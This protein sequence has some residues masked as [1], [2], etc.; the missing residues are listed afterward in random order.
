M[1]VLASAHAQI[2]LILPPPD[3]TQGLEVLFSLLLTEK[4]LHVPDIIILLCFMKV[5][6]TCY[7]A[8]ELD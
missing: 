3:N 5:S 4:R 2:M 1:W 8:E 6:K 7:C